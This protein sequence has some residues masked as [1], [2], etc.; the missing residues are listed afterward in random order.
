MAQHDQHATTPRCCSV[1][2][3]PAMSWGRP[4]AAAAHLLLQVA[5]RLRAFN[6]RALMFLGMEVWALS[7]KAV[8]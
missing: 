6:P 2:Q 5:R 1:P 3:P 7:I 8:V 4:P